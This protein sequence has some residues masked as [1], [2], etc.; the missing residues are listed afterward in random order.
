[1]IYTDGTPTVASEGVSAPEFCTPGVQYF[2]EVYRVEDDAFLRSYGPFNSEC[3][4]N[5]GLID[6]LAFHV[7]AKTERAVMSRSGATVS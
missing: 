7:D 2:V 5:V 4:A 1:M 6:A 3:D